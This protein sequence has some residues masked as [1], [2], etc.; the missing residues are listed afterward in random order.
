MYACDH[1][2]YPGFRLGN[3]LDAPLETLARGAEQARFGEAKREA[4]PRY[5]RECA[6]LF[7]CNG[8]CPK[9]RFAQTPDGEPGLNYLCPSYKRYF[10]HTA[11]H[12][13]VMAELL[14]AGRPPAL[15]TG[16]LGG[17][18]PGRRR[19]PAGKVGRNEPCPCGSGRKFK[20]CCGTR[21]DEPI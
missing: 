17:G 12:M 4:L 16:M 11:P 6:F 8:G 2:V 19:Q 1:Y 5:C 10:S 7:A 15:I 13:R 14:S 21:S 9:H 20:R 3:L 18:R